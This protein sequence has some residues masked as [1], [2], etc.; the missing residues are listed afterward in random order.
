VI[1]TEKSV[2]GFIPNKPNIKTIVTDI[3]DIPLYH[4]KDKIETIINNV[5]YIKRIQNP[6]RVEC[7]LP[8]YNIIQYSKFLWLE[9]VIK[10][11]PF[12]STHFFWMDVGCSRFFDNLSSTF[13]NSEKL[14]SKF[15][16]QGNGN[17]GRILIDDEY[18]WRADC[19]FVGTFFG[20]NKTYVSN[21]SKK[22]ISYLYDDMLSNDMINNE[23]IALA[24]IQKK[25]PE[26]FEI[27][28]EL[29]NQHLPILKKLE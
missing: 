22:V 6:K 12:N 16:I 24:C 9:S 17:T 2:I 4:I 25:Y 5:D 10:E 13:P 3:K 20:G 27:Y 11:N 14:P 8:M 18:K 23:Q 1:Y 7:V 21:V 29:N 26:L 28:I 19:V 15:L